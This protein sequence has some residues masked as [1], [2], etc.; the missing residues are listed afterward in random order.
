MGAV[1]R[2][3]QW[4]DKNIKNWHKRVDINKLDMSLCHKCMLGQIFGFVEGSVNMDMSGFAAA[5][6]MYPELEAADHYGFDI[7]YENMIWYD[8]NEEIDRRFAA[9][10][11]EWIKIIKERTCSI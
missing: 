1:A 10:Q 11:A 8:H 2:G 6:E 9:L 7:S 3:V 4:L 5:Q